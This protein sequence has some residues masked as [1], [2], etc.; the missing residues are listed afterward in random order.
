MPIIIMKHGNS[1]QTLLVREQGI[2]DSL[3]LLAPDSYVIL[4]DD[5]KKYMDEHTQARIMQ[6]F[7][8]R[9][10]TCDSRIEGAVPYNCP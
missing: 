5:K 3:R 8:R 4:M 2:Y 7:M 10:Q 1:T 6:R 9:K